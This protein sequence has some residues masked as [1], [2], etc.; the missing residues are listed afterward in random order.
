MTRKMSLLLVAIV[1]ILT[2]I[3][4]TS[5]SGTAAGTTTPFVAEAP[6]QAVPAETD[7]QTPS[8]LAEG[9]YRVTLVTGDVIIVS[10]D[11]AG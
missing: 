6:T 11:S 4:P 8:S 2:L 1:L 5:F 7:P 3:P 9:D 10:V